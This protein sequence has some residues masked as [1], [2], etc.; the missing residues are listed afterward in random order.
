M[1]ERTPR[2]SFIQ[3]EQCVVGKF[4]KETGFFKK[5]TEIIDAKERVVLP[6]KPR[7]KVWTRLVLLGGLMGVL[8]ALVAAVQFIYR[9]R[10][11]LGK[12][13]RNFLRHANIDCRC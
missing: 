1:I 6:S 2:M 4:Y 13:I 9:K 12:V 5:L 11:E 10:T 7:P 8:A 3:V